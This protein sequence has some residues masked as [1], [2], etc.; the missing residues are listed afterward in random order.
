MRK[1]DVFDNIGLG[2]VDGNILILTNRS[3]IV[4]KSI[5]IAVHDASVLLCLHP[6]A[7][8]KERW[9]NCWRKRRA[10]DSKSIMWRQLTLI[11]VLIKG[12]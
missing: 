8:R 11:R 12:C 7:R 1:G 5:S 6:R 4:A 10:A 3:T 9:K 2:L